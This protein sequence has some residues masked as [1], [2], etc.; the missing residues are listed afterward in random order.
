MKKETA[1]KVKKPT[2]TEQLQELQGRVSNYINTIQ[3]RQN[4][5]SDRFQISLPAKNKDGKDMLFN[6]PSLLASVLTAQNLG[7]EV[8]LEAAGAEDGGTLYVRFYDPVSTTGLQ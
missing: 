3:Y 5:R 2:V 6:V 1:L 7:K 4:Y 8:R